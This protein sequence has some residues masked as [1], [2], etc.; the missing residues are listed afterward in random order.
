MMRFPYRLRP[1]GARGGAG[2]R[3]FPDGKRISLFSLLLYR[4][5]FVAIEKD[6]HGACRSVL[7]LYHARK[8]KDDQAPDR[9]KNA[10]FPAFPLGDAVR[11]QG[12]G[13]GV[14]RQV[15]GRGTPLAAWRIRFASFVFGK[16]KR[17]FGES[18]RHR[19]AKAC[20][21]CPPFSENIDEIVQPQSSQRSKG[22]YNG[23]FP[24]F[25]APFAQGTKRIRR[26]SPCVNL[27]S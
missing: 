11:E 15:L 2:L 27:L 16:R 23:G 5:F 1:G 12:G 13:R 10:R 25:A 7:R 4:N 8:F 26:F 19:G 22:I 17:G 24:A 20:F 6:P 18:G 9:E 21:P 3:R 14:A